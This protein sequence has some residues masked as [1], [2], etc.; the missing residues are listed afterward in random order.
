MERYVPFGLEEYAPEGKYA[1]ISI[2]DTHTQGFGFRFVQSYACIDVLTL[3]F[4]DIIREVEG[5]VLFNEEHAGK[6]LAFVER[7]REA[8]TLLVHCYGGMSR[9]QA[10]GKF[11]CELDGF[12]AEEESIGYNEHVYRVLKETYEK[13]A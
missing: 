2:Q 8:D 7:I 12:E 3:Y 10:V 6:I 9:S 11:I 5:C 13:S 1:V 4:D